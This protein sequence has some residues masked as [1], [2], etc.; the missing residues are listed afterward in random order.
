[1]ILIFDYFETI[2]HNKSMDFDRGLKIFWEKYYIDKCSFDEI[3]NYGKE[4]FICIQ[5]T[6]K[7]GLEF[8][9]IKKELPCFSKKYGGKTVQMTPTEEADF[10]M[11][12][13]EIENLPHIPQAL[14]CFDEMDLPMYVLS[15]SGFTADALS[16]VLERLGIRKY[17]KN[18]WS[19]ADFGRIK[20]DKGFFEMAL[21]QILSDYPEEKK[22][23][24]IFI[25]DMYETDMIGAYNSGLKGIW[26][27]RQMQENIEN[28]PISSIND[29]SE[30]AN[31]ILEYT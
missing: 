13:N 30:L 1:M 27:N 4:L 24:I 23:D 29:T 7:Q 3:S 15:N 31:K 12:C 6:H 28:L 10:L 21:S 17:F 26:I 14:H 20:P 8:P 11:R 9:F 19:S 18:I 5:E 25:G 22:E 2:V 16:I